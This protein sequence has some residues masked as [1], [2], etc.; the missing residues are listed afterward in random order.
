MAAAVDQLGV[1]TST[2]VVVDNSRYVHVDQ[3]AL[4]AIAPGL[5]RRV[6]AP[7]WDATDHVVD[8]TERSVNWLLVLDAINFSFWGE[9]RWN[10]DGRNGYRALTFALS[11]A[12]QEGVPIA[13]AHY[14]AT[15][16]MDDL[17]SVLRG[18]GTIPWLERRL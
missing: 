5:A 1:L 2:G 14:L 16:T 4:E 9:P 11:R 10:V 18:D 15:M 8:G 6:T 12:V 13:D 7:E 3:A 17:A